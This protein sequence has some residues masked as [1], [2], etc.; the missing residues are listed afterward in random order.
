MH[1]F[2]CL[3]MWPCFVYLWGSWCLLGVL[4]PPFSPYFR[5]S[6]DPS[7]WW[8][9]LGFVVGNALCT[10]WAFLAPSRLCFPYST[11]FGSLVFCMMS[12]VSFVGVMFASGRRILPLPLLV[13]YSQLMSWGFFPI[14]CFSV[15]S[16]DLITGLPLCGSFNSIFTCVDKMTKW[17]KLIQVF[18][19]WGVAH[20]ILCGTLV[21]LTTWY[22]VWAYPLWCFTR[23]I[24]SLHHSSG[25]PCGRSLGLRWHCHWL[26]IYS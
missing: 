10:G 1:C 17:V 21:F 11:M 20:C 12:L 9:P 5:A 2:S 26:T 14:K 6:S 3:D 19:R 13:C 24:L 25:P 18:V 23:K 16:M 15:W 7:W 8:T 22:V 4:S